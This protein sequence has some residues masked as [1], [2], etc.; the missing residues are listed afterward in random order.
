[1]EV[2]IMRIERHSFEFKK[3]VVMAYLNGEGS[4]QAI[5]DRFGVKGSIQVSRWVMYYNKFGDSGLK[6]SGQKTYSFEYK[7]HI[8]QLYL[9][10][11]LSFNDIGLSEGIDSS[12]V[13]RWVQDFRKYGAD[14]LRKA[15]VNKLMKSANTNPENQDSEKSK[16]AQIKELKD[17]L[18]MLE[19]ENAY[20]K[21]LRRLRLE[22]QNQKPQKK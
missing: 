20:L 18:L 21:E 5:A 19:I 16:D 2:H 14:G 10:S 3:E 13:S 4:M 1:M 22:G 15:E 11:D 12:L 7:L 9:T 8:V 6:S 17:K